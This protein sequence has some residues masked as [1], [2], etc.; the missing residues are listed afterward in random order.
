MASCGHS[1]PN[2]PEPSPA[3]VKAA[4]QVQQD[5]DRLGDAFRLLGDGNYSGC[6]ELASSVLSNSPAPS[7]EARAEFLLGLGFHKAKQYADAR[8]HFESAATGA[9]FANKVALPYY[10]GWCYFWLGEL[11]LSEASFRLHLKS[12]DEG[13]SHFGLGVIA[14]ERGQSQKASTHLTTALEHFEKRVA[15]GDALAKLDA[16]KAQARLADVDIDSGDFESAKQRLLLAVSLDSNRAAVWYKIYQVGLE[17]EDK[18]L[19]A[20]GFA[21]YQRCQ[22]AK[23]QGQGMA[24]E[25]GR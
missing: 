2:T 15:S 12:S 18:A 1:D 21:E 16:A 9:S 17:L 24:T 14:L 10:Q 13:D 11:D 8:A 25:S 7:T 4:E 19:E 3:Q 22:N 5:E 20:K 23:D 6:R